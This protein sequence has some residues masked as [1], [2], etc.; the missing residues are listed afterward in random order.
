[1]RSMRSKLIAKIE[2]T[3]RFAKIEKH[4]EIKSA[5]GC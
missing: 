3:W 2:N 1:M 5:L 4:R